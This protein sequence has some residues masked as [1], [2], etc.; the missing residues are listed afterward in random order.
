MILVDNHQLLQ[1]AP[2]RFQPAIAAIQRLANHPRYE[3]A[4]IF[5]SVARSDTSALSD[6]D[7]KVITDLDNPCANI[8]HPHIGGVKLDL[9]F[10]SAAQLEA[11]TRAEIERGERIP[12][13]AESLIVFDKTGQLTA[14]RARAQQARP[15][16]YTAADH[17]LIQFWFFHMNDKAERFLQSDPHVALLAMHMN[18]NEVLD[19]HYRLRERWRLSSKRLL[20]DMRQW[21]AAMAHLLEAF[22]TTAD[23][24]AK[25]AVWTKIVDH[26][27]QPLGGRQPIDHNTCQCNVC[28]DD[29]AQLRD[30]QSR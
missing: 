15:K 4:F 22:V 30:A 11:A 2:P 29:L 3:A 1:Q 23:A 19:I 10:G 26:V 18:I 7:V 16:P 17:Q 12:M 14:L 6:L 21:D 13:L 25:F 27:L 28:R 24:Q 8:N 5:G 9:T 20:Q